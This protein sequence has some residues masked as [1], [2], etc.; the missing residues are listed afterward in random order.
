V[1]T[2]TDDYGNFITDSVSFT[3]EDTTDPVITISPSNFTV[4]HGYT[5][6]SLSWTATDPH[7]NTYTIE[8]IGTGVV[9]G[10][11]TWTS[12]NGITYNIPDG[13]AVGSYVYVVTF[14][15]DYGN[16]ITDSVSF[17]VQDTTNPTITITPIDFTTELGYTGESISWTA[18]D[19]NPGTYTIILQG[20]GIVAGPTTWTSGNAITYNIPDGFSVGS[21]T[22]IV[23]FTDDG[24]LYTTDSVVF[25]VEDTTNPFITVSPTNFTMEHGY[26]G[27]SLS[28]TATDP[29]PNTYTIEL[30]G[31]GIVAGPTTWTSGIA[32]NYNISDGFGVG[33]YIYII[34]FT[35]DY[36]NSITDSVNFSVEDTTDPIISVSPSNLIV[37]LGYTGQS[38]SWTATDPYPDLYSI[39][40]LGTGIVAGPTAWTSGN[41]ITY[42]IPDGFSLGTYVYIVNFMDDY[43][44]FITSIVNFTVIEDTTNPVIILSSNNITAEVGY[45]GL[46]ISWTATDTNPDT[47][48][49]ELLGTGIIGVPTAWTSG[50]PITY[51]IPDGFDSGVYIY[52]ITFTDVYGNSIS[53][54]VSVTITEVVVPPE[55]GIPFGYTFLIFI[56]LSVIYLL[57]AKKKKIIRETK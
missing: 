12:G 9:A 15:D 48:T 52:N 6:L 44:N 23:N 30:L 33:S 37:E 11:T 3:V 21:Y 45:T 53:D 14:T 38:L 32:I 31:T 56:G 4:E 17:S 24:G 5:G 2:F 40:L 27:Q 42:N 10:P 50:N 54:L 43:G 25:T 26:T 13:F 35:D 55:E 49:I 22:Y 19:G 39:Q 34:N 29:N 8:L 51:N 16:F 20:T 7:P 57:I 28:W 47:Y 41:A 1:V 18:V 46:S 36:G